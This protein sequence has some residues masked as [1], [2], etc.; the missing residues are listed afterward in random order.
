MRRRRRPWHLLLSLR[1]TPTERRPRGRSRLVSLH[2]RECQSPM[3]PAAAWRRRAFRRRAAPKS[4]HSRL[5]PRSQQAALQLHLKP[6]QS[7]RLLKQHQPLKHRALLLK[8]HQLSKHKPL[9]LLHHRQH[10]RLEPRTALRYLS[11]QVPRLWERASAATV[12]SQLPLAL[13]SQAGLLPRTYRCW[14]L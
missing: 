12:R 9:R 4:L 8:R 11:R 7:Q 13:A 10:T 6:H 3:S 2:R 5:P 14:L 1:F